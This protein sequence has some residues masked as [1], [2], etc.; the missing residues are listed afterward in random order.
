MGE[1]AGQ[2]LIVTP[3]TL[4]VATPAEDMTTEQSQAL[5]GAMQPRMTLP[6][7]FPAGTAGYGFTSQGL[8]FIVVEDWL[9]EGRTV[10]L[11]LRAVAGAT[12]ARAV[13]VNDHRSLAVRRDGDDWVIDLPVRPGDGTLIAVEE[14]K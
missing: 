5:A 6:I 9:E 8:R 4:F 3:G 7:T 12:A 2:P 1:L 10:A 11:K 14:S 13:D